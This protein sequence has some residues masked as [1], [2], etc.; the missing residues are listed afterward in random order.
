MKSVLILLFTAVIACAGCASAYSVGNALPMD[1]HRAGR[2]TVTGSSTVAP[3]VTE[4]AKRFE[5]RHP[6]VRIDVQTGGSGKGITDTRVGVA[7]IGMASRR[8]NPDETDLVAHPIAADGVGLIVHRSNPI[9]ELS[10]ERIVAIYTDEVN[11]WR[12]VGGDDRGITVVHKAEGR[13]TLE[14][15]LAH[16]NID[17]TKVEA[18]VLVGENEHAV[19]TVAGAIGAIGYVSIGTAEAAIEG[20]V[21]IRLLSLGGVEANTAN[22]ADGAFPMSRP[23]NL[24]TTDSPSPLALEFVR[25]CR[26]AD[27][28]DLIR[29]QYFV[30]R[31][32]DPDAEQ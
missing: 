2:L 17:N 7:D 32:S 19:K 22:I 11:N 23:L 29:A 3:L 5:Q 1:G 28:H 20:G 4:I 30:P 25:F 27:V 15:F 6:G 26:S 12:D 14:V 21:P 31:A 8:L 13:A 10:A 18:D 9:E 24:V 16:F